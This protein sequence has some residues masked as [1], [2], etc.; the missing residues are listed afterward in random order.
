MIKTCTVCSKEKEEAEFEHW[1][2]Q[3]KKC[4]AAKQKI[5]RRAWYTRNQKHE[6]MRTKKWREDHLEHKKVYR[7]AEYAKHKVAAKEAVKTYRKENPAKVNAWSRKRQCAKVKRTPK[8]VNKDHLWMIQEAYELAKTREQIF[9]F[10]WHVDH[11]IPLRG[12]L[13]SGLHVIQNLQVI[14]GKAN[15]E[16]RNNFEIT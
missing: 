7:K 11:I 10:S 16:K 1:R 4:R 9:G 13:V 5:T 2:N 6:I 14:P 12:K 3:C 8:W 15:I